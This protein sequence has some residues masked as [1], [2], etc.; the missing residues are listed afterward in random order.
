MMYVLDDEAA[1]FGVGTAL[2]LM[3]AELD[4]ARPTR[5]GPDCGGAGVATRAGGPP[6]MLVDDAGNWWL[7]VEGC[8]MVTEETLRVISLKVLMDAVSRL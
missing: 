2:L 6:K 5:P 4:E 1:E 8:A 3:E 7:G